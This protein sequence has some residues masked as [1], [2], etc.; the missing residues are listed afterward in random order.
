[1]N[2]LK[3]QILTQIKDS[4]P[5]TLMDYISTCLYDHN[6][7]YYTTKQAIFSKGGDFITSSEA[8]NLFSEVNSS[9]DD[10]G[11]VLPC[12]PK[13]RKASR[14]WQTDI[15]GTRTRKWKN[16]GIHNQ[17]DTLIRYK[18]GYSTTSIA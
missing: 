6:Y 12:S 2:K 9:S 17:S 11:V 18:P 7:G 1:M 16:D 8:S 4:G 14:K 10:W 5:I 13:H 15:F 3:R